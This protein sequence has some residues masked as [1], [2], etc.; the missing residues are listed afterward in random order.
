MNSADITSLDDARQ[1]VRILSMRKAEEDGAVRIWAL[2][3]R[4]T[5]LSVL[6][7]SFLI[8]YFLSVTQEILEM[9]TL[10]VRVANQPGVH[11]PLNGA[12]RI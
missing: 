10:Q 12:H 5:L 8:Y 11:P 9:P 2:C 3:K 6:A 4:V 7:G 1:Y